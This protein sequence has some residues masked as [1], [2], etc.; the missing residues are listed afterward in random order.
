MTVWTM[1]VRNGYFEPTRTPKYGVSELDQSESKVM[2]YYLTE[3]TTQCIA[4]HR[5]PQI[6]DNL[7]GNRGKNQSSEFHYLGYIGALA[8]ELLYTGNYF[9]CSMNMEVLQPLYKSLM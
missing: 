8:P 6:I 9:L 1:P 4:L 5:N 3:Y 7:L 2:T